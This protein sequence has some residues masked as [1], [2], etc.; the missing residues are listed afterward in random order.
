MLDSEALIKY[1]VDVLHGNL[2]D[3][4]ENIGN[5]ITIE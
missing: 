5:R 4:Y 2:K 1:I 3:L